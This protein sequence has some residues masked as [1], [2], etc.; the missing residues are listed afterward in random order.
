MTPDEFSI[1]D[2]YFKTLS[3]H[4]ESVILG[5]GDDCAIVQVSPGDELCISTDTLLEGVHFPNGSKASLVASRTVGANLSDLAAMGARPHSFLLAMTLPEV[6]ESWLESFS[7]EL[8]TLIEHYDIP[9]VGG[10]LARGSLSLTMT[11]LGTLPVGGAATRVGASTG[12]DI[13]AT[14][15]LGD[16]AAGLDRVNSGDS[17]GYLACRYIRPAPRLVAGENLRDIVT[18]MIDISD[19][20]I[21]EIGHLTETDGLGAQVDCAALP[22]S[23][24]LIAAVGRLGAQQRALFAG[25]DYEL[26]FT[27][28]VQSRDAIV[29]LATELG[30]KMTRIGSITASDSVLVL[31]ED[32]QAI[33]VDG[34]GYQHF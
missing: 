24:E 3:H 15:T 5:P 26:C 7:A 21:A 33:D 18:S 19:G 8:S 14:G 13:Y 1:I 32:G 23:E 27:A 20:L 29:K 2:R 30:L 12:D 17:T 31:D 28:G 25:D 9:L 16:A 10:N 22:L 11:V 34:A 6:D 4:S